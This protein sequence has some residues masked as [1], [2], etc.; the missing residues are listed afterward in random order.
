MPYTLT[1]LRK[2]HRHMLPYPSQLNKAQISM[3]PST[4]GSILYTKRP[5][6]SCCTKLATSVYIS[7]LSADLSQ[8]V[9]LSASHYPFNFRTANGFRLTILC[10]IPST[11]VLRS[12]THGVLLASLRSTQFS[13]LDHNMS[14]RSFCRPF[15]RIALNNLRQQP[16][17]PSTIR[18]RC[19][20]KFPC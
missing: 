14:R 19:E 6:T 15:S 20:M 3:S 13:A 8:S 10:L 16:N 5:Q 1:H 9:R 18:Q 17:Q 7:H 12:N 11:N 4:G 2:V